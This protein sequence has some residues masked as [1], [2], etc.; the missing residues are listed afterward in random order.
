MA[1]IAVLPILIGLA[2]DYAIQFQARYDEAVD[3]GARGAPRPRS[4]RCCGGG[5][6]IATACLATAAGFL[7]LQLS[8]TRWSAASACCSS[9]A[10]PSLSPWRSPPASRPSASGARRRGG[11][12]ARGAGFA[13]EQAPRTRGDRPS[14]RGAL[15]RATRSPERILAV[16]MAHPERVLGVGLALAVVGWGV[17]TQIDTVSPTSARWR[18]RASSAVRDLN[19]LQ[20]ATGVSG[21]LDVSVQA[22]DLTDPGDDPVDGRVQAAGARGERVRRAQTRAAWTAEVCPGPALSD[23]LIARRRTADRARASARRWRDCRPMTCDRWRRS[24]R[25]PGC[26]GTRRCSASASARSRWRTSRR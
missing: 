2:V 3:V 15:L 11:H 4:G 20:D 12:L 6:T 17:G 22:P 1:S 23:F 19:E 5:P 26:P 14:P 24:T 9:S 10:S 8:P 18:R 16:A 13:R 25:R 21:E 7:A